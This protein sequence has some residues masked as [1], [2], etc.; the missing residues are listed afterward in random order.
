MDHLSR[1]LTAR[2]GHDALFPSQVG[3]HLDVEPWAAL[4]A[5]TD[6]VVLGP[7]SGGVRNQVF[8]VTVA[9]N[10][11]VARRGSR[12]GAALAWEV[13]L[14]R[15]LATEGVPVPTLVRSS[16]HR[17][18][19]DNT[20]V[21]EEIDGVR[22][23]ET[24]WAEIMDAVAKVHAATPDWPQRPGFASSADLL[25]QD[26]GGD[27]DLSVMPGEIVAKC[28]R[29][30]S[31]LSDIAFTAVHGDPNAG[32]AIASS[33]GQLVLIDWDEARVDHPWL[34]LGALGPPQSGLSGKD[35][36]I[37]YQASVAWEVSTCW[38]HEPAYARRRLRELG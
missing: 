11:C 34:D 3:D 24:R 2:T 19:V 9:G 13:E 10:R 22:P 30:W 27:V 6:L 20:I 17:L 5:W 31:M 8:R 35:A 15:H 28:R 37:A 12:I 4:S 7:V 32:N 18:F 16:D 21:M 38:N 26:S 29:A 23:P 1:G 25:V 33:S 36:T 14:L